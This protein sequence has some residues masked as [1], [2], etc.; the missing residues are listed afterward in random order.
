MS[1]PLLPWSDIAA[2]M[3]PG[4]ERIFGD[5]YLT[6]PDSWFLVESKAEQFRRS[7]RQAGQATVEADLGRALRGRRVSG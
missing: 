5:A 4:F 2:A 1:N 3:R 6:A 7:L